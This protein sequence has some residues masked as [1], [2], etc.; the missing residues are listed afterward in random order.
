MAHQHISGSWRPTES[1]KD[2]LAMGIGHGIPGRDI[3]EY[4]SVRMA[5]A[6][7]IDMA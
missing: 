6:G 7:A 2:E 5:A 3:R 1:P 4:P